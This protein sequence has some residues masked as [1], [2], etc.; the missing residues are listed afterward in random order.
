[1]EKYASIESLNGGI[2][3]SDPWYGPE[4]SCQ[5]RK[6]FNA[7][8]WLMRYRAR[9][10]EGITFFDMRLGRNTMCA[11]TTL[12]EEANGGLS[13]SYP[14]RYDLQNVELG[15]DTA[16]IFCGSMKNWENWAEEASVYTG[17]D[18]YFGDLM[19]F[20]CKG[21]KNP[22]GFLLMGS[23]DG[24]IVSG[25]ELFKTLIASFDGKE[26][27][28]DEYQKA[29]AKNNISYKLGLLDERKNAMKASEPD[30]KGPK[31]EHSSSEME[32]E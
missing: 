21:E 30:E 2:V 4:V 26:I 1:M 12:L 17:A 13:I 16:R 6:E 18:G 32:R 10:E 11:D 9:E 3:F 14:K 23:V 28:R 29:T 7:S 15:I 22:A 19:V 27:S 24:D 20:T 31:K 8:S 5:Y 25:E